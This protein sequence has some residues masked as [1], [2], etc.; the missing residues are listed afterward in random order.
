[1]GELV[2]SIAHEIEQPLAAATL[3]LRAALHTYHKSD[4]HADAPATLRAALQACEQASAIVHGIGAL[5]RRQTPRA[6]PCDIGHCWQA[7]LPLLAGELQ[8]QRI[9]VRLDL[10]PQARIVRADGVQLQQV[11]LNLATN[12]IAAMAGVDGRARELT[13]RSRAAS[14]ESGAGAVQL[15][16]IDS[17]TGL[18]PA[19]CRRVFAR[20]YTNKAG[21]MGMGLRL[22]RALVE[23]HGGRIWA[24][25]RPAPEH[26][27]VFHVL[28]PAMPSAPLSHSFSESTHD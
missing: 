25:A 13:I 26:G 22:C 28:L 12:A 8:R 21:G 6:A 18:A 17:G 7:L 23:S 1:M 16:L 15:S 19:A 9:R 11:L 20:L 14:D 24:E 10:A 27:S 4:A 3:N 2:V 5:A